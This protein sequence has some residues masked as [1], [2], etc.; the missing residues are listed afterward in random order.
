MLRLG[1]SIT[2]GVEIELSDDARRKGVY[3][4]GTTGSGKTTLLQNIAYQDMKAG[5]GLCVL[6]PHGDFVDDLLARVPTDRQDDVI[7]FAPGSK[8]QIERPLGLNVLS[9]DR[10]DDKAVYRV[11][12]T[13]IDTLYKLFSYSWGPRMEDLLRASVLTLMASPNTTLLDLLLLLAS[14]AHRERYV[15]HVTDPIIRHFWDVQFKAYDKR[16]VVEVVGSSLNKIGRFLTHPVIRNIVSQP[17]NAF[18]M[19]EIMDTGKILLVDLSKGDLG[20]D[21]SALL[22]AVLVNL[23]LIAALK[24]RDM[25]REA[26]RRFHLIVDEYQSFATQSFPTL[27]SEARKYGI[28]VIV[29]HQYRDQLDDLN[30]GSTLNV[31]NFIVMRVTGIDSFELASQ[32]DNT[33]PPPEVIWEPIRVPSTQF[34][35]LYTREKLEKP[36]QGP[37]R[38]YGDVQAER[39][40]ELARLGDYQAYCR[41]VE[42]HRLVEHQIRTFA[43]LGVE[44]HDRADY[45]RTT[46]LARGSDRANVEAAIREKIGARSFD[47][48]FTDEL[49]G[50]EK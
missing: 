11:V 46:S 42:N 36:V 27:Q 15:R 20:E 29:A 40:N 25:P 22:G 39:A 35:G 23:I 17:T 50:E 43:P 7:Y 21:N 3:V 44:N 6:D 38:L 49:L 26:R 47:E 9:C 31:A 24:R 32:F 33:P 8:Q 5:E 10:H 14:P 45:I 1:K 19:Q 2:T 12:S 18:D 34:D 48:L 16:E 30:R 41:L 13:V 37:R 28:D 4:I